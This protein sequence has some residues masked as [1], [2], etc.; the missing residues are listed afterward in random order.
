MAEPIIVGPNDGVFFDVTILFGYLD[1]T[2]RNEAGEITGQFRILEGQV[3]VLRK[4][5]KG[6]MRA[7]KNDVLLVAAKAIPGNTRIVIKGWVRD[8]TAPF[9]EDDSMDNP[10]HQTGQFWSAEFSFDVQ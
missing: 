6:G 8:P 9:L 3:P 10:Q 2:I 5:I 4:N 1:I 7:G